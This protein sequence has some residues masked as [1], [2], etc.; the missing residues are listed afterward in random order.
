MN[1]GERT[2]VER[3]T[4]AVPAL[5]VAADLARQFA[6][7]IRGGDATDLDNWLTTARASE[8]VSFA[9]GLTRDLAAVRAAITEPWST[10]PVE[11]QINRVKT[12]KRQM[13]GRAGHDLLRIRVLA[14]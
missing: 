3:I 12:M 11:G 1:A 7:M 2:F 9:Q 14:A 6:A 4:D 13:Y 8:L 10:S 5:G